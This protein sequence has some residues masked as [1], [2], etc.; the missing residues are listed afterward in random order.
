MEQLL[1]AK[2]IRD[3]PT[4]IIHANLSGGSELH[5]GDAHSSLVSADLWLEGGWREERQGG[6]DFARVPDLPE[7][8]FTVWCMVERPEFFQIEVIEFRKPRMRLQPADC[9][10]ND[11]GYSSI[12]LHVADM[13]EAIDRITCTSGR[14]LTSPQGIRGERRV[15]LR[16]PDGV[17]IEL[18]ED[19]PPPSGMDAGNIVPLA[20]TRSVS[21]SVS[22]LDR[23]HRFWVDML[24]LA[25][26]TKVVLHHREH[27]RLWGLEGAESRSVLLQSGGILIELV[28]YLQPPGRRRPAGYLLSDQGILNIAL[29]STRKDAFDDAFLRAERA[30]FQS[31]A[32][33][34]TVP[35]VATV[36]YLLDG[37]GNT[38]E[39]LHVHPEALSR[40][41]FVAT[42][43]VIARQSV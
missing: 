35:G 14:F 27:E 29:G 26:A 32:S 5:G 24:G 6:D 42:P 3:E 38:V 13:D 37:Q 31:C 30:G 22:D 1:F 10:R 23:A 40:M 16:D 19:V 9:M 43:V 20:T 18:M 34:W 28:Q 2:G 33:P 25:E 36:A 8:D 11:L 15:C 39:L 21:I 12:G 4:T 41:G 7:V 17:L